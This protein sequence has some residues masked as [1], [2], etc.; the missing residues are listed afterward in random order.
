MIHI[1]SKSH[2]F[3]LDG[4][5]PKWSEQGLGKGRMDYPRSLW[6]AVKYEFVHQLWAWTECE[7]NRRWPCTGDAAWSY[8]YNTRVICVVLFR[9]KGRR[10]I[11]RYYVGSSEAQSGHGKEPEN[12]VT[13][14]FSYKSLHKYELSKP[15][16]TRHSLHWLVSEVKSSHVDSDSNHGERGDKYENQSPSTSMAP[17]R[18]VDCAIVPGVILNF[19]RGKLISSYNQIISDDDNASRSGRILSSRTRSSTML[20]KELIYEAT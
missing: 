5:I 12:D 4:Q 19:G 1:C 9:P 16:K 14:K 17:V 18:I 11:S 15:L 8:K 7:I 13:L 3:L 6:V 20:T 2:E 10:C